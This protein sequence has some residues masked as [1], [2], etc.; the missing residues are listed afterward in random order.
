MTKVVVEIMDGD[1]GKHNNFGFWILDF[2][3]WILDFGL[4]IIPMPHAHF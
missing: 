1:D 2:G 3:F 4:L